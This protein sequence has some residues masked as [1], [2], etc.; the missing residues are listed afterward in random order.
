MRELCGN[1]RDSA[2]I[3]TDQLG[4][5]RNL[6]HGGRV[7]A[8]K[9]TTS[10]LGADR[11]VPGWASALVAGLAR[12]LPSVVTR[13]EMAER[14][15]TANV[16]RNV[17]STINELRRL[18]WLVALPVKGTWAFVPPGQKAVTDPYLPLRAWRARD[19][20]A[21]FLLAGEAAAWHLGYLDRRWDGPVPV[22]KRT[23]LRLPDGLRTN[24]SVISLRWG[25]I[26]PMELQPSTALLAR[27]HLD[28]VRWASG[29]PAFGPEA[30]L[31][32][33]AARPASFQ[34]WADVLS[35][36]EQ[37]ADDC[38][39]SRIERLLANQTAST[40]Q[41]AAYLLHAGGHPTR[42]IALV[43]RRPTRTMPKVYLSHPDLEPDEN[44]T[45]W[46]P[47]YHLVDRLVAP[48]RGLVGK[49]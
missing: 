33:L 14:L 32:Q 46:V 49:G 25:D 18:G 43:D 27:R 38:D 21:E 26:A 41:R 47:Q 3:T 28:L 1:G 45:L 11:R 5:M 8:M 13:D 29:F 42:G 48:L 19:P 7:S 4:L 16:D 44:L 39:D 15:S 36:L 6:S 12:D 40:W 2:S 23:G 20:H 10:P 30:L 9:S 31:V 24:V 34:P 17:A 22:W 35:H 37:L